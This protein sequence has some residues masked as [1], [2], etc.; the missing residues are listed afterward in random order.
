[1]AYK[2]EDCIIDLMAASG[3]QDLADLQRECRVQAVPYS[4]A[5]FSRAIIALVAENK[6]VLQENAGDPYYDFPE[7]YYNAKIA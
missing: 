2:C 3:P 6:I 5:E 4:P 7:S 1:M